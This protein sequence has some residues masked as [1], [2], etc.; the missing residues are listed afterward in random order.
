MKY[1]LKYSFIVICILFSCSKTKK[2]EAASIKMQD[3]VVNISK[4]AR[5]FNPNFIIIPQNG[6]ELAFNNLD[7]NMGVNTSY[8]HAIDGLG[9]EELFYNGSY[10]LDNEKIEML[11]QVEP[12]KKILVSEYIDDTSY[13]S[14]AQLK[15]TMENFTCFIRQKNNYYYNEIPTNL[16]NENN[17]DI[18]KISDVKNFLYLINNK[19]FSSKDEM[20]QKLSKTNYDLLLIDLFFNDYQFSESDIKKLKIKKNGAKR[21]VIAY[22]SIGSAEKYRYYWKKHWGLHHPIWCKRKYNGYPDEY[23]VKF[24]NKN[25]QEIIFNNEESYLKKI[26]NSGFDGAYLDNVEAYYFNYHSN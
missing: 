9:I 10:S 26:I 25:W 22:I 6:I 4:Y 3:F 15:N 18:S 21:I 14:D 12:L 23:W 1:I 5:N 8:L 17:K 7:I 2:E 24:W 19:N 13:Y 16:F 20:I 11:R